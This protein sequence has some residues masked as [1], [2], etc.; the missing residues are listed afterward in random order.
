VMAEHFIGIERLLRIAA[1]SERMEDPLTI[2]A[3][4]ECGEDTGA[5]E[6]E[7]KR[8]EHG[9]SYGQ[10]PGEQGKHGSHGNVRGYPDHGKKRR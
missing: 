7:K 8:Q 3:E 10:R 6:A 4:L 9:R 5:P 2:I 1:L